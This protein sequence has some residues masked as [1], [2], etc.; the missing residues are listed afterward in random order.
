MPT[1]AVLAGGITI[2]IYYFDHASGVL[3]IEWDA[4]VQGRFLL[5]RAH[6]RP[7]TTLAQAAQTAILTAKPPE[8][9][10]LDRDPI[11]HRAT[12]AFPRNSGIIFTERV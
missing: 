7:P 3:T 1:I 12:F 2:A 11:K 4:S 6:V 5:H 9:G 10:E 8:S